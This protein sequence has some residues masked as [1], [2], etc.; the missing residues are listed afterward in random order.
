MKLHQF[1]HYVTHHAEHE[2]IY[3]DSEGRR[4]VVIRMLDLYFLVNELIKKAQ[5]DMAIPNQADTQ[6]PQGTEVQPKQ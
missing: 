6:R 3:D 1:D 5:H 2:A 4:I